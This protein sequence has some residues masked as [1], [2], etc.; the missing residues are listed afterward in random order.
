M[1]EVSKAQS[2]E[3]RLTHEFDVA[4]AALVFGVERRPLVFAGVPKYSEIGLLLLG[5]LRVHVSRDHLVGAT[6]EG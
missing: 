3:W 2:W 5:E 4:V 6:L 1:T